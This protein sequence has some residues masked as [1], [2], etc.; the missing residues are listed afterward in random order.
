MQFLT[1]H[2]AFPL[3]WNDDTLSRA[4]HG[5]H[6]KLRQSFMQVIQLRHHK[7]QSLSQKKL[8]GKEA[9]FDSPICIFKGTIVPPLP[10]MAF[11]F[12]RLPAGISS[13]SKA[14][15]RRSLLSRIAKLTLV[16]TSKRPICFPCAKI[17]DPKTCLQQVVTRCERM[18]EFCLGTSNQI[19]TF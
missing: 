17:S 15:G 6:L 2:F 7:N 8:E 14:C 4:I 18:N 11:C 9:K 3:G 16:P 5:R 10:F 19:E 13:I 1:C 12:V